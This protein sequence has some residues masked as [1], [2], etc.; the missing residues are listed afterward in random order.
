MD[1][2]IFDIDGTL[3]DTTEIC[4]KAWSEAIK[5]NVPDPVTLTADQLKGL[6]GKPMNVI[7][8]AVF[9]KLSEEEREKLSLICCEYEDEYLNREAPIFFDGVIEGIKRLSE[10]YPLYIVSNCQKGYIETFLDKSGLGEY[11]KDYM[12]YGDTLLPKSG[13]IKK[14]VERNSLKAPVYVGDTLGDEEACI[15]AGIP[16]IFAAYGFGEAKSPYKT[17]KSFYE[18]EKIF[19]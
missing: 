4:A 5:D 11:I 16:F 19:I 12:C 9:P 7:F 1:A 6:F 18:L 10:K 17:I 15:E 8:K 2:I 13:T 3:W 14:L